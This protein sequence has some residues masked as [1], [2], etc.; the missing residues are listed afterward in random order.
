M[1]AFAC[2]PV[3]GCGSWWTSTFGGEGAE[4]RVEGQGASPVAL[5]GVLPYGAYA[6]AE[7]DHTLYVS[8]LPLDELLGGGVRNGQFLHAQLLWLPL[9]GRT[10]VD[11]SAMNL[12]LRYV[13]VSEGEVGVYGGGGFAW[14][15]GTPGE[16]DLTLSIEGSSLSLLAKSAG[17]TDLLSPARLTGTVT[18]KFDADETRR[19]RR[20][21]S[22]VVT[23]ALG[24]SRW[25]DAHDRP[26]SPAEVDQVIAL[27]D[28]ASASNAS[29][30]D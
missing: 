9:P 29:S 5:D 1:V 27:A 25:V 17:F 28:V 21:V 26:L 8:D 15:F 23:D 18:A 13:V 7:A 24:A 10:P 3:A 12:T 11:E 19:F 30:T 4:V 20:G 14:P 16:G 2:T 22:Q 6:A